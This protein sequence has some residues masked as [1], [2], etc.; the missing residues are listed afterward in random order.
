MPF[1]HQNA[2]KGTIL[3]YFK[4]EKLE[5]STMVSTYDLS[6]KQIIPYLT[7]KKCA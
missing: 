7:S 1:A 3:F 4:E 2:K 6:G 5:S